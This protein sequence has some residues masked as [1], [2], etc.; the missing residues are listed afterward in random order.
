MLPKTVRNTLNRLLRQPPPLNKPFWIFLKG[1]AQSGRRTLAQALTKQ[2][3]QTLRPTCMCDGPQPGNCILVDLFS[4]TDEDDW[5]NIKDHP[6][7]VFIRPREQGLKLNLETRAD[8]VLDLG[9][10]ETESRLRLW[11]DRLHDLGGQ[12]S[13]IR[14]AEMA[15]VDAP[16]GKVIEALQKVAQAANWSDMTAAEMKYR[17]KGILAVP[18]RRL[19]NSS[20]QLRS[21]RSAPS[22]SFAWSLRRWLG[23][24]GFLNPSVGGR[25]ALSVE[26]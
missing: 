18:W 10:L 24:S 16:P 7:W 9:A 1:P 23:F 13:S 19:R 12:F 2:F 4:T 8:L 11:T 17:L 22:T 5:A 15:A 20:T 25:D 6:G 14:P 21:F 26:S 3:G